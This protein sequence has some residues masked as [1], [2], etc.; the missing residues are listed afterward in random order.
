[1]WF[2][3]RQCQLLQATPNFNPNNFLLGFLLLGWMLLLAIHKT[4][5]SYFLHL[6]CIM[7]K[8]WPSKVSSATVNQSKMMFSPSLKMT[9]LPKAG[10]GPQ[11]PTLSPQT[12]LKVV[13]CFLQILSNK[14]CLSFPGKAWKSKMVKP[15][16]K[17]NISTSIQ[18][19]DHLKRKLHHSL[20]HTC[21]LTLL[22][23]GENKPQNQDKHPL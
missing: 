8:I 17:F 13:V 5:Y 12:L 6:F 23:N 11:I 16:R 7:T 3:R 1:M 19:Y 21:T 18:L 2:T 9:L 10:L 14:Y 20:T 22:A 4:M 15:P